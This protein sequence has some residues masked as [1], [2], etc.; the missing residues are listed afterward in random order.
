MQ[1]LIARLTSFLLII[2]RLLV[3]TAFGHGGR[4]DAVGCHHNCKGGG[5]HCHRGPLVGQ[6]FVYKAGMLAVLEG[7]QAVSQEKSRANLGPF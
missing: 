7:G 4:L 1:S 3:P 6:N 2:W 5:Y